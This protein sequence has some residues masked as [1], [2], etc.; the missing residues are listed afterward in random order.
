MKYVCKSVKTIYDID[1]LGLD[2]EEINKVRSY[3]VI[4]FLILCFEFNPIN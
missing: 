2:D 4:V 1:V 3:I